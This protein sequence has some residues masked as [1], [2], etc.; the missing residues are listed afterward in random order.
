MR[1][2]YLE[3]PTGGLADAQTVVLDWNISSRILGIHRR[4]ERL[5]PLS[6]DEALATRLRNLVATIPPGAEILGAFAAAEPETRRGPRPA[7]VA[8]YNLRTDAASVYLSRFPDYLL[9]LLNGGKS[10]GLVLEPIPDDVPYTPDAFRAW[11][12]APYAALLMA[13]VIHRAKD[14]SRPDR[15]DRYRFWL[16]HELKVAP[17]REAWI[18]FKLL[19]GRG[20]EPAKV[21]RL[22]KLGGGREIADAVWGATWD[23]MYTRMPEL[24]ALPP[25]RG[26]WPLPLVFV[27][28][29]SALVDALGGRIASLGAINDNGVGFSGDQLDLT[30]LHDDAVAIVRPYMRRETYRVMTKSRGLTASAMNR[31]ARL[32]RLLER[33]LEYE[34]YPLL[35]K[36]SRD[37]GVTHSHLCARASARRVHD[38]RS[39]FG[40]EVR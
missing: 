7:D 4:Q 37:R 10:G 33:Q 13:V 12:M 38:D 11:F 19:G 16:E 22:L 14:V 3:V 8:R 15:V 2:T 34:P 32:A 39:D 5:E 9:H 31:A 6:L 26:R 21:E 36:G 17:G 25:Y 20:D 28:D 24:M 27:T 35:A 29:D 40:L 18:G 30:L 1:Q 23:M